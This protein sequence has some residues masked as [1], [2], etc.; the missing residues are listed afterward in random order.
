MKRQRSL[1]VELVVSSPCLQ[2]RGPR[3]AGDGARFTFQLDLPAGHLVLPRQTEHAGI[4][5]IQLASAS[6][7]LPI[8]EGQLRA[9][10]S[11]GDCPAI[12]VTPLPAAKQGKP[13]QAD[14]GTLVLQYKGP[15]KA[16][17]K[18]HP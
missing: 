3:A 15:G 11:P 14:P 16:L 10:S 8:R 6:V 2:I 1:K 5:R 9:K 7:R 18:L 4:V 17:D 12:G 13:S